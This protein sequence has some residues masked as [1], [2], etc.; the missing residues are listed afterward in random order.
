MGSLK[1]EADWAPRTSTDVIPARY[2]I[3][4]PSQEGIISSELISVYKWRGGFQIRWP[5][6][7]C[8]CTTE[9]FCV[10]YSFIHQWLYS[11]VLGP[12]RLFS[13]VN[14]YTIDRTP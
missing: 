12:G 10:T 1:F 14:L 8:C 4:A 5:L 9:H 6:C 2:R 7:C 13:F 11:P 3:P